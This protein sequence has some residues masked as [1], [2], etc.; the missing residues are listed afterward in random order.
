MVQMEQMV[1]M[2]QMVQMEAWPAKLTA[3]RLCSAVTACPQRSTSR[4][5]TKVH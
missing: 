1:Q 2:V 4:S 3:S 5:T